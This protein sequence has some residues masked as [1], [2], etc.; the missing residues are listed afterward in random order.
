LF[1]NFPINIGLFG[2]PVKNATLAGLSVETPTGLGTVFIGLPLTDLVLFTVTPK[3][4][5]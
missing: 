4:F 1:S 3:V 5:V 2:L